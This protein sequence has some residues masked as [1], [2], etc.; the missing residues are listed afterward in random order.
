MN[1]ARREAT[2]PEVLAQIQ[3]LARPLTG[4]GNL[5]GVVDLVGR[6]LLRRHR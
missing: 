2:V 3:S 1:P 5:D 4:R 6:G